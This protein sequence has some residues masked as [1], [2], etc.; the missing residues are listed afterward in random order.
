M[1]M[2]D[3][4]CVIA[5]I[6]LQYC[7]VS[8]IYVKVE[9]RRDALCVVVFEHLVSRGHFLSFLRLDGD[10]LYIT[11]ALLGCSIH[12]HNDPFFRLCQRLGVEWSHHPWINKTDLFYAILCPARSEKL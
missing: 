10:I 3:A 1:R 4:K 11:L 6:Y 12:F 7:I 2:E 9:Y 8:C 5:F